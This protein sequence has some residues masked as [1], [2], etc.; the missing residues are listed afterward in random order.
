MG[1]CRNIGMRILRGLNHRPTIVKNRARAADR[2]D[3]APSVGERLGDRLLAH[4]VGEER[5]VWR[6][7]SGHFW[8]I[9]GDRGADGVRRGTI[10]T[11]G[12]D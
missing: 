9:C 11:I 8:G 5:R 12:G 3:S 6:G 7:N 2:V 4:D 1:I 10:G